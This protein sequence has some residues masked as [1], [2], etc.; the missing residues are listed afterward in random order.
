MKKNI[1]AFILM[2]VAVTASAQFQPKFGL[3]YSPDENYMIRHFA[4]NM[5]CLSTLIGVR[6]EWRGFRIDFDNQIWMDRSK[7]SFVEFDPQYSKFTFSAEYRFWKKWSAGIEHDCM[8]PVQDA[9]GFSPVQFGGGKTAF[10]L[11]YGY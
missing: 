10:Y 2:L 1:I 6:Y 8:H 9:A 11:K 3:Q 4:V 5:P 7:Y